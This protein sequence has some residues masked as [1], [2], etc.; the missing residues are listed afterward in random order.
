MGEMR[1]PQKTWKPECRHVE[2]MAIISFVIF[3]LSRS[4]LN[5]LCRK[6]VSSFFNPGAGRRGTCRHRHKNS[7]L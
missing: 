1:L 5:T 3:P 6:I 7:H 4:I 2:S